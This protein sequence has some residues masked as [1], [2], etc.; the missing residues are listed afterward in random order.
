MKKMSDLKGY[1]LGMAGKIYFKSDILAP[2]VQHSKFG[3]VQ[4]R[5]Y[6][7]TNVHEIFNNPFGH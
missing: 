5:D 4:S 7:A 1:I 6:R 2:A 3:L